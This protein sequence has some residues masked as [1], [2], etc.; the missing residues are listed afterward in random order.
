MSNGACFY[1]G[2]VEKELRPYGPDGS[3]VCFPCATA[4]PERE[5]ATESAFGA[6]LDAVSA[7]SP[8]VIIGGEKG[9][10]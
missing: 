8:I 2:S 4:T 3:D 9:P 7:V 5:I 6:L 10:A 1:C